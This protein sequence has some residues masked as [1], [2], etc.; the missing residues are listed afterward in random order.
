M[1]RPIAVLA[2]AV[3]FFGLPGSGP[4][5]ALAQSAGSQAAGDLP[6]R[7]GSIVNRFPG[8]TSAATT[9]LAAELVALGPAGLSRACSILANNCRELARSGWASRNTCLRMSSASRA[10]VSACGRSFR[11]HST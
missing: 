9:A 6:T 3:L 10:I 7:V 5:P 2:L 1:K 4:R 8:E 11:A